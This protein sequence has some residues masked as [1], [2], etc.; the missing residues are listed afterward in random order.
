MGHRGHSLL[1]HGFTNTTAFGINGGIRDIENP[2]MPMEGPGSYHG[3]VG[4][5]QSLLS[6]YSAAMPS[7]VPSSLPDRNR[8]GVLHADVV[9]AQAQDV[10][11]SNYASGAIL[12]MWISNR[13][14]PVQH[15]HPAC[16]QGLASGAIRKRLLGLAFACNFWG[17]MTPIASLQNVLAVSSL[18]KQG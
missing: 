13:L 3:H 7:V 2:Q 14:Y 1:R 6:Y 8:G 17:M 15:H 10:Y 12:S 9:R 18:E 4:N 5:V 11:I 16:R